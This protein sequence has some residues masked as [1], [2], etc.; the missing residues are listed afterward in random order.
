M[1]SDYPND[2]PAAARKKL[3]RALKKCGEECSREV[4]AELYRDLGVVYLGLSKPAQ[5][6]RA[7][8]KALELDPSGR[9][10]PDLATPEVS[11]A[12]SEAADSGASSEDDAEEADDDVSEDE[13]AEADEEEEG[14]ADD[15]DE[16]DEDDEEEDDS[17]DD[18]I[19]RNWLSL[20]VQQDWLVYDRTRP[21]CGSA[22]YTCFAGANEYTGAIWPVYGNQVSGGL[23]LATTRVL[24]GYERLIGGHFALGARAGF[25]FRGGPSLRG[26]EFLPAHAELRMAYYFGSDPFAEPGVRPY[27]AVGGGLAEVRG[28][29]DVDYYE[30]SKAYNQAHKQT[31]DAWRK[32]G[33]GFIAPTLGAQFAFTRSFALTLEVRLLAMLGTSGYAPA[34]SV[35]FSQGL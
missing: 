5:A 9:L 32:T 3:Q 10:D 26:A 23:A 22:Q 4:R 24:V 16:D 35:G 11:K 20:S 15:D 14:D 13:E 33:R 17:D 34:A 25:A 28:R 18:G 19:A 21:V 30:D 12:F 7:F 29:V 6:R 8:A 1:F 31:L 2:Q 27:L